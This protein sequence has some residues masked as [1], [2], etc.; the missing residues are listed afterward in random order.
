MIRFMGLPQNLLPNFIIYAM[1]G[2]FACIS[3]AP[4]TAILLIT[5]M[6]GSLAHLM[7]LA[8]VSMVAYLVVDLL[9]GQP[10]YNEMLQNFLQHKKIMFKGMTQMTT[11]I[12][13]GSRL[14]D[15]MI[16]EVEWPAGCLILSIWRGEEQI[17]PRGDTKLKVGDTLIVELTDQDQQVHKETINQ[18]A[19]E[20]GS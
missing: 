17:I 2:Y 4:F 8:V 14:V 11:S 1:A 16:K 10:V 18:W 20:M 13:E 6:V 7:P 19:H 15:K 3:K 9:N 12:Y 5:E